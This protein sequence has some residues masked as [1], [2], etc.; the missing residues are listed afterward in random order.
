MTKYLFGIF[1]AALLLTPRAEALNCTFA[2]STLDFGDVDTLGGG[3][4]DRTA[5]LSINCTSVTLGTVRICPNIGAG[6][7]GSSGA[8]RYMRNPA[9]APLEFSLYTDTGTTPWGSIEAA[10]LGTPPT[11]DLNT[12]LF[13]SISTTR[14]IYGRVSANQQTAATGHYS[15]MFTSAYSKISYSDLALFNCLTLTSP[16]AVPFEVKA[17]VQPNCLVTADNIDFGMHGVL[18]TNVD[19]AGAVNVRCTPGTSYSVGLNGGLANAAPTARQMKLGAAT[20]TYGLYQNTQRTQPWSQAVGQIASGTGTGLVQ[21]LPV[22][23]RVPAQT[24]PGAG[25]YS[26]TVVATVTY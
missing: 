13:G 3:A 9:N 6:S 11:I 20:V 7:G 17:D 15:S 26:D 5:T 8:V 1:L 16:V 25:V 14:T 24:T 22:Y 18:K 4:V 12:S 19:A 23:G 21:S 10:L 2:I